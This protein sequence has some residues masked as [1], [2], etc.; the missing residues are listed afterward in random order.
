MITPR[1]RIPQGVMDSN[2]EDYIDEEPELKLNQETQVR[3]IEDQWVDGYVVR[4]FKERAE[5]EKGEC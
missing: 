3:I 4:T 1:S 2:K 5:W